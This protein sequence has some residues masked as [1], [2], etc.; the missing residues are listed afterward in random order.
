MKWIRKN[1]MKE[2][3]E[4]EK[5]LSKIYGCIAGSRIGSSMSMPTEHLPIESIDQRFGFLET[6]Q[7]TIQKEKEF[8]W[9]HGP[10]TKKKYYEFPAGSTEDG[11]ER[12]KLISDAIIKKQNRITIHD[13][14]QSWMDNITE[15]KFGFALHWSDKQYYEMVKAGMHPSYIGLFSLWP[16][17]V[18][19][20]RSCHPIGLIN[21]G[22]PDQ[23]AEDV[24]NIGSIYHQVHGTGLQTAAAY[25]AAIAEAMKPNATINSVTQTTLNY[26]DP[27]VKA[28]FEEVLEIAE[29]STDM[30]EMRRK[31]ND[32]FIYRYGEMKSSGEEIV[33][34]GLAIFYKTSGNIKESITHGVNFARDTDCTTAISAGLAGAFSGVEDIPKE[35]IDTVDKATELNAEITVCTRTMEET[36]RGIYNALQSSL[37]KKQEL[38]E[39]FLKK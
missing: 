39:I 20:A 29:N 35:W 34:R 4:V 30:K 5:T 14:A 17:I 8:R 3:L 23:A 2:W 6:L 21:A 38:I 9:P 22:D 31:I 12:Q 18:T 36:S 33:A 11:I 7:S 25:A 13:L 1:T 27:F 15:Q 26:L 24:Y 28:E 37:Q 32:M 16:Q 19:F 10:K